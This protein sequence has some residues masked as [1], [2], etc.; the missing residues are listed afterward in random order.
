MDHRDT[1]RKNSKQKMEDS[2]KKMNKKKKFPLKNRP[3]I[4][5]VISNRMKENVF[6]L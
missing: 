6:K 4:A 5:N 1:E 3:S 2:K